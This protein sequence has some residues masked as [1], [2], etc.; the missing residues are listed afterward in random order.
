MTVA[1]RL[2]ALRAQG[3]IA[4]PE[5]QAPAGDAGSG[6][7]WDVRLAGRLEHIGASS[8]YIQMEYAPNEFHGERALASFAQFSGEP[9]APVVRDPEIA[10][11]DPHTSVFLDTETTGLNL[12]AGTCVFLIGLAW[13]D[14]SRLVARQYFLDTPRDEPAVL[15][16]LGALLEPFQALITFNGKSFDWPML[17]NRY[18]YWRLPLPME[19]PLHLDLLHPAR[20]LWRRRLDSCSLGSLEH[21]ILGLRRTRA[22]VPGWQIPALYFQYQRTGYADPLEG[23]FYHNLHDVLSMVTLAMHMSGILSD[24]LGGQV[25]EAIDFFALGRQLER[26]EDERAALCFEEALR[27]GLSAEDRAD[28]L[29]RLA[30]VHRRSR[31]WAEA[32]HAWELI[33]DGGG[34]LTS[35]ALIELAKYFE[36]VERDYGQ[37]ME[38]VQQAMMLAELDG[39]PSDQYHDLAHRLSRLMG[40]ARSPARG[41]SWQSAR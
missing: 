9:L 26:Q 17:E 41:R 23:V 1:Q 37:S 20:R 25:R 3:I 30:S 32:C 10:Y 34:P 13:L 27:L 40:R 7:G 4:V 36:H 22:D 35:F 28:C 8:F 29:A 12:G 5:L 24:P 14:G 38:L 31:R 16:S 11:L 18:A 6:P 19:R 2:A 15:V 39:R 21:H 33:V